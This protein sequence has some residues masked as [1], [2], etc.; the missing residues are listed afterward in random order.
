MADHND[1]H[2][3]TQSGS[4]ASSTYPQQAGSLK[5]G[6]YVVINN[7]PCKVMEVSTSKTGKHGHAKANITAIDIFT[8]KKLEDVCPTSHNLLVPNVTKADY[9]VLDISD[10]NYV[11]LLL[12]DGETKDNLKVP[13]GE[14]GDKFKADFNDGKDLLASILAAMDEE[15]IVSYKEVGGGN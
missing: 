3:F 1:D 7:R 2:D 9:Q 11:S 10:D 13:E 8:G 6:G 15:A 14:L 4:G 5:K 12:P